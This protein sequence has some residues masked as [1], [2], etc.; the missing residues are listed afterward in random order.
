[1][2]DEAVWRRRFHIFMAARLFGLLVFFLGVAIAF[3]GLLR[4]GGWPAVGGVLAIIGA[5][6]AVFAPKLLKKAWE[7]QDREQ[8]RREG[9]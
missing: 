9:S 6:D 3:T 1:M 7:E 2:A 5:L 4:E 8:Q